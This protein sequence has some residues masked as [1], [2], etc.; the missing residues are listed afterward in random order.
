MGGV[1]GVGHLASKPYSPVH[2][3]RLVACAMKTIVSVKE[4]AVDTALYYVML[5]A[6]VVEL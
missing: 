2:T 5:V 4:M 3:R 1:F 6:H